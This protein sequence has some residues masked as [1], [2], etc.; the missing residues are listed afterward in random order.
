MSENSNHPMDGENPIEIVEHQNNE[1]ENNSILQPIEILEPTEQLDQTSK[2]ELIESSSKELASPSVE[3]SEG[4][5]SFEDKDN[6]TNEAF[7]DLQQF[8]SQSFDH[9]DINNNDM[10][11]ELLDNEKENEPINTEFV[12]ED[13]E[14]EVEEPVVVEQIQV[15]PV[16]VEYDHQIEELDHDMKV[17]PTDDTSDNTQSDQN[18]SEGKVAPQI[19]D[20]ENSASN[21]E[22]NEL[23]QN[24]EDIKALSSDH[25]QVSNA[26]EALE[27]ND[28]NNMEVEDIDSTATQTEIQPEEGNLQIPAVTVQDSDIGEEVNSTTFNFQLQNHQFATPLKSL[29]PLKDID[30]IITPKSFSVARDSNDDSHVESSPI[31]H[32]SNALH[33]INPPNFDTTIEISSDSIK[34]VAGFLNI[35][36]F[37][38]SSIQSEK[39]FEALV[40][41]STEFYEL[42]SQNSYLQLKREQ[43]HQ[44]STK[45]IEGL[46]SRLSEMENLSNSVRSEN[47]TLV[48]QATQDKYRMQELEDVNKMLHDKV[49]RL[50]ESERKLAH[51]YKELE[52]IQDHK[53]YKYNE[54]IN[55]LTS[56]N[57]EY[58]KK[59]NELS[60]DINDTRNEKFTIK[61]DLTKATN[62]ISYLKNQKSW[63]EEELK[64][65]Q[66]RFTDLIKKH[67]S[68][69][70]LTSNKLS[71]LT[72]RNES[73]D[74]MNKSSQ[75]SIKQ[76]KDKL[77][78]DVARFSS[79]NSEI[80][81]ENTKL[82]QELQSQQD[83]LQLTQVQSDQRVER[84][85]QLESYIEEI[86]E[87]M[88]SSIESLE[89][90]LNFKTEKIIELQEKLRR[91]EEVLDKELQKESELPRLTDSSSIIA[92]HGISLSSLYSEFNHLKKQLVLERSQK[93]K[94]AVQL[95]SFVNELESKKPAIA[96]YRDQVKFYET[97]LQEM[98]GKV[99]TVRHEKINVEK[100]ANRL[101]SRIV[102]N[103]N[104]LVSMKKLLKDLGKQLCYYLI[105]SK[106]RDNNGDPLSLSEKKAIENILTRS[107]N[108]D[109]NK[110]SDSDVLISERLVE[111]SSI[112]ELRKKNEDLLVAVRQLSKKLESNEEENMSF[113]TA[114]VEEAKDAI[115]TLEGE[116]DSLSVKLNAVTKER[117][118]LKSMSENGNVN[119]SHSEVK[120]LSEANEDL[121][122]KLRESEKVLKDLQ[123]QSTKIAQELNNKLREITNSKNEL[124]L[125]LSSVKH[126]AEL[127]ETRFSNAQ[128]TLENAREEIKQIKRDLE[129]WKAQSTKQE[130]LLVK[131]SNELRDSE[132]FI[133][134]NKI[135]ISNLEKEKQFKEFVLESLKNELLQLRDDK[136]NLNKFVVNLQGLLKEREE[137]SKELSER[138]N[139][140]NQNYQLLQEKLSEKEERII[141]LA[142]QAEMTMKA[143]NVKLEQVGDISQLLMDT[144]SKLSEKRREIDSLNYKI[145]ELNKTL[146]K[147]PTVQIGASNGSDGDMEKQ[148]LRIELVQLKE[149]LKISE[150]QVN[151][152]SNLAKSSEEALVNATNSFEEFKIDSESR[153]QSHMKEKES[154]SEEISRLTIALNDAKAELENVTKQN[155]EESN[156]LKSKLNEFSNKAAA[157][158]N[159]QTDYEAK[160]KAIRSDLEGQVM[161]ATDN[162]NKYQEEM[163]KNNEMSRTFVRLN[164]KIEEHNSVIQKLKTEL[165]NAN[166]AIESKAELLAN[167]KT[168][169]EEELDVAKIQLEELKQQNSV[170]LNQLELSKGNSSVEPASDDLREVVSY[171]RRGK[172]AAEAKIH[173]VLEEN[174]RL[175]ARLSQISNELSITKTELTTAQGTYLDLNKASEEH[176]RLTQQLEHLNIL[177][178]S[179]TTLRNENTNKTERIRELEEQSQQSGTELTHL[180]ER[181]NQLATDLEVSEQRIKLVE[182]DNERLKVVIASANVTGD[183]S[184]TA[185]SETDAEQI[186]SMKEKYNDLRNKANT[187]IQSQN[188]KIKELQDNVVAL[189]SEIDNATKVKDEE[190]AKISK[191]GESAKEALENAKNEHSKRIGKLTQEKKALSEQVAQLKQS[192]GSQDFRE[193]MDKL[194]RDFDV[195]KK[196]LQKTLEQKFKSG[197]EPNEE[198]QT[199]KKQVEEFNKKY[200]ELEASVEKRKAVLEKECERKIEEAVKEHA[201]SSAGTEDLG[202]IKKELLSQH[203]DEVEKLKSEFAS[204]L[205]AERTKVKVQVEKMFEVKIKM[206]NKK[207]ER[208]EKEKGVGS[209]P[210]LKS[211]TPGSATKPVVQ[212]IASANS[213]FS[214]LASGAMSG[215]GSGSASAAGGTSSP[216]LPEIPQKN[217]PLGYPFTES[218]LTVHR[219][220]IDRAESTKK[221][222]NDKK[223]PNHNQPNP[224][225]KPKDA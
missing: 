124:S 14:N 78:N 127:A 96:N 28:D 29:P 21:D 67:E 63:Y 55:Q 102:E 77:E 31:V 120:Y 208:L 106:I 187:R 167:K 101:R 64:T 90:A 109:S 8:L 11:T 225:K 100:E 200:S 173:V 75:E 191:E 72:S 143:Q 197:Q 179:N 7:G 118:I 169:V 13:N 159:L 54:S 23:K 41:K 86:K 9:Q 22:L 32:N 116:L 188:D 73:L 59:V 146:A 76:L 217:K 206:L 150:S 214:K 184:P 147:R 129:F 43:S 25:T 40:K 88:G 119:S 209:N 175:S 61:L 192:E 128:T 189:N 122:S 190:I 69:H 196:E 74:K 155:S 50:E 12:L 182:E 83:L 125:Q 38:L 162:Q 110:E 52:E 151:E 218:T 144:K 212:P 201:T 164:E 48:T 60:K 165:E 140:S 186:Q 210:A 153:F 170:I 121:K 30:P 57:I 126:S 111:F 176:K 216:K 174:Q 139:N 80:K 211:V 108:F 222:K 56:S 194:R 142:S 66:E 204:Q 117:D 195:E 6:A 39:L 112:I 154:L 93:E 157:Y 65:V 91:T 36:E 115:L 92:S 113:Q 224:N 181:V 10:E 137:L 114:A 156:E 134:K 202:K 47:E 33:T 58:S 152:L 34:T 4:H 16:D 15:E 213:A 87:K 219:P 27:E 135:F 1:E 138:L 97:S 68:E 178:E 45:A 51:Q 149:D 166:Q 2:Q 84:I 37:T 207:V 177:R 82:L 107:G 20:S 198:L 205:D 24:S 168:L 183:A 141:I 19:Q 42:S 81:T 17:S 132:D 160:L 105:H 53:L 71:M 148:N 158:D 5:P 95:E 145:S 223:R 180:R 220:A 193:Q 136:N 123:N 131:K 35:D 94:L 3:Q 46:K 130:T 203:K 98:I 44:N 163:Q 18:D 199:L 89:N 79:A 103:E 171:L 221:I 172:E 133:A 185:T 161:I 70:L 49:S 104:E 215:S 99:E 85:A 62:E 26:N